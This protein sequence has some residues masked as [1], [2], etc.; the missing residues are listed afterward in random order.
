MIGRITAMIR[1]ARCRKFLFQCIAIGVILAMVASACLFKLASIQLID[2]QMAAQ[3]ATQARTKKVI[4]HSMRGKITDTNG[5]VLAQSVGAEYVGA[6]T[7]LATRSWLGGIVGVRL[8]ER[9]N[10]ATI[11]EAAERY[12]NGL[13]DLAQARYL[14][15]NPSAVGDLVA[16]GIDYIKGGNAGTVKQ[17]KMKDDRL[18]AYVIEAIQ[19]VKADRLSA[20]LGR[21]LSSTNTATSGS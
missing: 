20:A 2:G 19:K 9:L 14:D 3:A 18:G 12:A 13:I 4:V 6:F 10:R 17:S 1:F 7:F 5:T 21:A 11:Q 8:I 16:R 15:A